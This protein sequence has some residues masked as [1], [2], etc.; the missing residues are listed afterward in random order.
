MNKTSQP[1]LSGALLLLSILCSQHAT[2]QIQKSEVNVAL[3]KWGATATASSEYGRRYQAANVLDGV[4]ES[5]ESDKWNSATETVP[6]WLK[7]KL[8]QPRT[9]HRV[10]IRH[11]GVFGDGEKYNTSDFRIQSGT[12]VEGPWKDLVPPIV[13]NRLDVTTHDFPPQKIQFLRILV[14]RG[15]P[16]GNDY[17]RIF[18]VEAWSQM[19]KGDPPLIEVDLTK[20]LDWGYFADGTIHLISSSHND[21]AWFDTPAETIARRD[22]ACIT[23]ALKKMET[24]PNVSFCMENV[25]YLLE[26]LDRHPE[27]QDEIARL[28]A[29]GQFDWGATYNQPYE[30]LL[31]GEQ[32]V[33]ELYYGR[34][35]IRKMIPDAAANVYY[36]PDV[37]GRTM[38]MPH[39][40]AKSRVPYL[41]ISRQ[42]PGLFNWY[43]PDG[44]KVLSWSMGHY[45]NM[46]M[47]GILEG[48]FDQQAEGVEYDLKNWS[49]YYQKHQI[50][51]HFAY[52]H[53]ADYIPPADFD[54]QIADWDREKQDTD[55]PKLVYSS[56]QRFFDAVSKGTPDFEAI[57]GERP[58]LWLYIHGPTHHHAISAKR[59]AAV[60]LPAAETFAT[61]EAQ[62]S[63]SF[64]NYPVYELRD[65]WMASIYDDHGWGG[66][67]GD[68]T[69]EVFRTK[70]EFA[71]N[72]GQ[73]LLVR[74]LENITANIVPEQKN[75]L[76]IAVYNALS[77]IRTDPVTLECSV[78]WQEFH[79]EDASGKEVLCQMRYT[80]ENGRVAVQFIAQDIPSIGYKTFYLKPGKSKLIQTTTKSASNLEN[81]FYKITL[82]EGGI[83][84][85]FDKEL[86]L[87]LLTT[88]KFLGAEV[89]TMQSVGNG[90]G[91]FAEIQQPD[92]EGFAQMGQFNPI[93][94]VQPDESGPVSTVFRMRHE[95]DH[96]TIE[97]SLIIYSDIKRID[98]EISLLN[99]DGTPSREYR[100]SLP[101]NIEQAAIAY[102]VP[103]GVVEVG[104][105]EMAGSAGGGYGSLDYS[106]ICSET[107][108]RE[109]Q[110]FITASGENFGL[111]MS[112]SVAVA[113]WIDPTDSPVD[114][115]IIQPILLASRRSCHGAGNW[116]LQPGDHH[117][118]F[119]V[120]SHAPGWQN[121]Y[122][123]AKQANNPLR[124][125][126]QTR[127]NSHADLPSEMSFF[128]T[129]QE[130]ILI[131]TVKK[132]EDDNSIVARMY[133]MEGKDT[134]AT[135]SGFIRLSGAEQTNM[136]EETI[137]P[138]SFKD[139]SVSQ[140]IGHHAIETVKLYLHK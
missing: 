24:D 64:N 66:A 65:A 59:E 43:S 5:R 74:S 67:N 9:I 79:L 35:L 20:K 76:T 102:E 45:G 111:T 54:G 121:G 42:R 36:N 130:N 88:D 107:H 27:K 118:R 78:P 56:P 80:N 100:M 6:H 91:E 11:E 137:R 115:P 84:S 104:K 72:K 93:W 132:G 103:F 126:I 120:F 32:L 70:L 52:L 89:M 134:E 131:S 136:I 92:M 17:A 123:L 22:H 113:D 34:K 116:Y 109:I 46:I 108:P 50:Q 4:W 87:E 58:G 98:I 41:L 106:Q 47:D 49:P 77:W 14:D 68:V 99:W 73:E 119:S 124:A 114:Y 19:P 2:A 51:P 18:E 101:L 133:E 97:E 110:D 31:S 83:Q 40:L 61:I 86:Q 127:V 95:T 28:T 38:Q 60:L 33:R 16:D 29:S 63:G 122:K 12:S 139:H 37:P 7:I 112:S 57:T 39:I 3:A 55:L 85:I 69:D 53:S 128:G 10:I 125:I 1:F 30:G 23:P 94:M 71:R 62:L 75:A 48:S 8:D 138:I 129:P 96:C 15:E 90:A 82:K 81:K 44:S 135:L 140:K 25:L 117:Y 13:Q 105:S 21:I 26:Y